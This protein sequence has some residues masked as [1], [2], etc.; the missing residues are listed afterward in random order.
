MQVSSFLYI[1]FSG[2]L[3]RLRDDNWAK[4]EPL[5]DLHPK[6]IFSSFPVPGVQTEMA[7]SQVAITE[8]A[9]YT[10]RIRRHNT[11]MPRFLLA[12]VHNVWED[13]CLH[14]FAVFFLLLLL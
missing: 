6:I 10:L 9:C 7:S 13:T 11:E 1:A 4:V 2:S 5:L 14:Y 12:N 8:S 3:L